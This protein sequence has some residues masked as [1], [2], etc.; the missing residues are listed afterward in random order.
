MGCFL[1]WSIFIVLLSGVVYIYSDVPHF[2]SKVVKLTPVRQLVGALA[3][4]KFIGKVDYIL[5]GE[6]DGPE[7]FVNK[8]GSLYTGLNSG[9]LVKIV[10]GKIVKRI[11]VSDNP[12]CKSIR[13]SR[14]L[15][16]RYWKEEKIA[17]TD[18]QLGLFVADFATGTIRQVMATTT[19]VGQWGNM[20]PDDLAFIDEDTVI[21]SDMSGKCGEDTFGRCFLE[22]AADGR[23]IQV[24]LKTGQWEVIA[25]D[26]ISP[27]GVMQHIDKDSVLVA[28][29][30]LSRIIRVYYKGPK[31]GQHEV[32]ADGLPGIVDNLRES[33][34]GKTFWIGLPFGANTKW[35]PLSQM[36]SEYPTI[37][38]LIAYFPETVRQIAMAIGAP[39]YNVLIE[40]DFQGNVVQSIHDPENLLDIVTHIEDTGTH[41]YLGSFVKNVIRRIE[42]P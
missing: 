5:E 28:Q 40:M 41:L 6:V 34:S 35:R 33:V 29:T 14:P 11:V 39:G 30:M 8:N 36:L 27:N 20:F 9:E 37:R 4:K 18:A 17:Y 42:K 32:F 38:R 2:E 1:Q 25:K 23:L 10:D 13:C 31:K 16:L 7:C 3:P 22:F 24:N 12:V 19:F 21:F 26:L 15:G